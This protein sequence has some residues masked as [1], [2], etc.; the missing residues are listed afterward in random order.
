MKKVHYNY[1]VAARMGFTE[2]DAVEV[3]SVL[4]TGAVF[5]I[6]HQDSFLGLRITPLA[7]AHK[8]IGLKNAG[9]CALGIRGTGEKCN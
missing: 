8:S 1:K 5:K 3:L 7:P 9:G 6:T 4:N 2:A